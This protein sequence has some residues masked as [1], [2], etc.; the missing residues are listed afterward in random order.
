MRNTRLYID[1]KK[2]KDNISIIQWYIG[3]NIQMML[4]IKCNAYW[5]YLNKL[6]EL[7]NNFKYVGVA[8]VDEWVY[9]RRNGYK[10]NIF[11][12]YPPSKEEL[13]DII[14]FK[15]FFNGCDIDKL[16]YFNKK[17]DK[18][19]TIHIEVDTG[20]GRTGIQIKDIYAYIK[21]LKKL[22]NIVVDGIYSHLSSSSSD[23][24]FSKLQIERFQTALN[25]F[26]DESINYNYAHIYNSGA[27]F[28]FKD[29]IFNM[30]RIWLLIYGYYP[31]DKFKKSVSLYPSMKLKTNISF[32][33]KI[34]VNDTVGYNKNFIA[35]RKSTIA[36]IPFWFGDGFIGLEAGEPYN[37]YVII[38][39]IKA[40]II[41]IC[42]DNS[43]IDVTDIPKIKIWDEVIIFDNE[44][45]TIE[46]V[47][48]WCN[49]ICNYEI[50]ASLSDRIPRIFIN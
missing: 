1:T 5:T 3:N 13:K 39:K 19:L 34:N 11:V 46:E 2:I 40:P 41:A 12:L 38:N 49:W 31:D 17:S 9:L 33:K 45:L 24:D 36:T 44:Q 8:L 7:T 21:R 47:A 25:I 32:I 27:I 35:K 14:K 42:M 10:G 48:W 26:K 28:S 6:I 18:K 29:S 22:E 16:E 20:M 23:I 37:P 43:M 4:I 30:V 50:I 15:L